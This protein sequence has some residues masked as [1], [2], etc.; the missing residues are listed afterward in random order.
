MNAQEWALVIFT[1]AAQ[2]SVGAFLVLGVVHFFAL[3]HASMEEVDQLSDRAL[4]AIGPVLIFGMIGSLAHLGT[5]LN[6]YRA[7]LNLGSSWLSWEILFGVL[8]AV[9][10]G[11]FAIMQWQK[12]STFA[13]RNI[14]A[15]IAAIIGLA[16]VFSMAMVYMRPAQPAWN[17][18]FT[19]IR[20][21]TTTFL[22]GALAVGASFVANYAYLERQEGSP[23]NTQ[24]DLLRESLRWIAVVSIILLGV[25]ILI[26]PLY[27]GNLATSGVA[28]AVASLQ[29]LFSG[30]Y[31]FVLAL[32]VLLAFVGAGIFGFFLYEAA[33]RPEAEQTMRVLVYGAFTFVLVSEVLGR[34]L[35]YATHVSIGI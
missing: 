6:A 19:P 4:L 23:Q 16:L 1:I 30:D 22:L 24:L 27:V 13:V 29:Q 12:I 32:Q 10:G 31:G 35:F 2:M 15:W 34:F 3:R 7:V 8:F 28:A 26:I 25:E 11:I 17:N 14:I 20:F 9:F 5:P 21:F 18:V 33:R